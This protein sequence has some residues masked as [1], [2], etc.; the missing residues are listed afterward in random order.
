MNLYSE[1][2][3][4]F[5]EILKEE[6]AKL[7][8]SLKKKKLKESIGSRKK[9]REEDT[10]SSNINWDDSNTVKDLIKK[11]MGKFAKEIPQIEALSPNNINTREFSSF[12]YVISNVFYILKWQF[13]RKLLPEEVKYSYGVSKKYM[14]SHEYI[15]NEFKPNNIKLFDNYKEAIN[16][17]ESI[18]KPNGNSTY[19]YIVAGDK[20]QKFIV[21]F[22]W[23]KYLDPTEKIEIGTPAYDEILNLVQGNKR[24]ANILRKW[25]E[26]VTWESSEE[27]K[28]EVDVLLSDLIQEGGTPAKEAKIIA[29]AMGQELIDNTPSYPP[30][31]YAVYELNEDGN[32]L[33]ELEHFD[34]EKKA[35][36]WAKK[37]PFPTH[38]VFFPEEDPDND[39][40]YAEYIEYNYDYEPYEV[41]W[42]SRF[43]ES[44]NR[45]R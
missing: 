20:Q 27:L 22:L 9:L 2:N 33:E 24:A 7:N 23:Y 35:I 8:E 21:G 4:Y 1:A 13:K 34:T 18:T 25:L 19:I 28:D 38:V 15:D 37:Q 39:P 16:Y 43:D 26:Y 5:E 6:S 11:S 40:D 31:S 14:S 41:V 29:S 45:R 44:F 12:D 36:A 30:I 32:E 3:K 42:E 10:T 17:A